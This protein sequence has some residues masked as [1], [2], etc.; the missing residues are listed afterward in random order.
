MALDE[1]QLTGESVLTGAQGASSGGGGGGGSSGFGPGFFGAM[2]AYFQTF[3]GL[4]ALQFNDS[5]YVSNFGNTGIAPT[6]SAG[7]GFVNGGGGT[8]IFQNIQGGV[9][10]VTGP[11]TTSGFSDWAPAGAGTNWQTIGNP[12]SPKLFMGAGRVSW[13]RA[14]SALTKISFG[15]FS[16]GIFYGIGAIGATT[17]LQYVRGATP[18]AIVSSTKTIGVDSTGLLATNYIDFCLGCFDGLHIAA[19]FDLQTSGLAAPQNLELVANLPNGLVAPYW[20][21]EGVQSPGS[22][23]DFFVSQIYYASQF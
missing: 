18:A 13:A 20:Y 8:A 6:G 15:F 7:Q 12:Q 11:N 5:L 17:V 9:I 3:S 19:N 22:T 1:S 16:G 10:K 2:R 23:D 14:P 21:N 4:G